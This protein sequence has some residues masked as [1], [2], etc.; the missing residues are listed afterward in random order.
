MKKMFILVSAVLL[1][2]TALSAQATT[3]TVAKTDGVGVFSPTT[4]GGQ[5]Y[6]QTFQLDAGDDT[7]LDSIMLYANKDYQF[8]TDVKFSVS[9]STWNGTLPDSPLFTSAI[10]T[11]TVNYPTYQ[12][13]TVDMGGTE[14]TTGTDYFWYLT[15]ADSVGKGNLGANKNNPYSNGA[16]YSYSFGDW[17]SMEQSQYGNYDLAFTMELSPGLQPPDPQGAVPEPATVMLLGM[18]LLGLAGV[19]RK[20]RQK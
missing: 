2:F 12:P 8:I 17:T 9:V 1:M 13:F 7:V 4:N 10:Q 16:A 5:T 6:G 15:L 20:K 11:P 3:I 19:S 18:G 14:L